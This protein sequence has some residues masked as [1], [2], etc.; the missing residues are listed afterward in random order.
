[1]SDTGRIEVACKIESI[2]IGV[3]QRQDLGDLQPLKDSM[4]ALGL[5]QPVT[6]TPDLVLVCGRRRLEAAKQLGWRTLKVW[7]RTGLSERLE[8]LL[9][10]QDENKLRKPLSQLEEAALFRELKK[11]KSEDAQRRQRATQFG[12]DP[13][14][15]GGV[16]GG[17]DSGRPSPPVGKATREAALMVSGSAS[18]TRLEQI[19]SMERIAADSGEPPQVRRV[20]RDELEAIRNGGHVDP[21]Y[22][23]VKAAQ[24][25]AATMT[26]PEE[27]EETRRTSAELV[28]EAKRERRLRVQVNR[29]RRAAEAAAARRSVRAFVAT[30]AE[31]DGWTQRF[32]VEQLAREINDD[33]WRLF[34][35]VL[36][37]SQAF[38][39]EIQS[40]RMPVAT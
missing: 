17:P 9:A 16:Y 18:H 30:W 37:E 34:R 19:C 13:A 29:Q 5:L 25:V 40:R 20:A 8:A 22:Q 24:R 33:D 39:S 23:R 32:D 31:L 4:E 11:V 26:V 21:G 35:R 28:E 10:Q 38:A 27:D 15:F 6:V 12:T 14:G 7:V 2:I 3:R 36:A 1:M